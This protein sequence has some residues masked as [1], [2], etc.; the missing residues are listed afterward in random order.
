M[1][2]LIFGCGY[3]GRRVADVWVASGYEVFAVTRSPAKADVLRQGRIRPIIADVCEPASLLDL[4]AV[5][6]V[7][8]AIGFD[9]NSGKTQEE[10]TCGGVRNI[11]AAVRQKC[12]RF[13]QISSTSVYGQ[14]D[15][16]WVDET[17]AC[18][19]SQPGGQLNLAA[20]QLVLQH[21]ASGN[22]SVAMI[23]R[24][25]GIYG[26]GRLLSRIDALRASAPIA[27]RGDSWLNL[28]HVDDAVTAI[29]A[30]VSRGDTGAAYNVVDDQPIERR[31]YFE[32]LARLIGAPAPIF[33][34]DTDRARGSGGRNKR[35]SNRRLRQCLGWI[36]KY[37]SIAVGLPQAVGESA[38]SRE[39]CE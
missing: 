7:L 2:A 36:P 24:L 37:P 17:S 29:L 16:E 21:F 25:A 5:D 33:D 11:L 10:V 3:L 8:H 6:V 38:V 15:G 1:R 39:R 26:P 19:P 23:L 34:P 18:E 9:R 30:C 14:S 12:A 20:E 22:T 28:I 13:I 35:C 32:M 27:G 31:E 4:P